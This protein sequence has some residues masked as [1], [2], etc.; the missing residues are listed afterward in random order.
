MP[1]DSLYKN[2]KLIL[3]SLGPSF[4]MIMVVFYT[5]CDISSYF[6]IYMY[7]YLILN[8]SYAV[9]DKTTIQDA[10]TFGDRYFSL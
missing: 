8:K 2:Q 3:S 4:G 10:M 7:I 5:I 6:N 1:S 9:L